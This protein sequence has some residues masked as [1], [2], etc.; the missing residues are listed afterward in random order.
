MRCLVTRAT[1]K[2][3]FLLDAVGRPARRGGRRSRGMGPESTGTLR[4]P[5]ALEQ[6]STVTGD[7]T[8]QQDYAPRDGAYTDP[9]VDA[10][11][12]FQTRACSGAGLANAAPTQGN[13]RC[14]VSL[15]PHCSMWSVQCKCRFW[16][17]CLKFTGWEILASSLSRAVMTTCSDGAN[18]TMMQLI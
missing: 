15:P 4:F 10:K 3:P 12:P 11:A 17:S 6:P 18:V 2:P 8:G 9:R 16:I 13:R 1:A 14:I 7:R 5:A